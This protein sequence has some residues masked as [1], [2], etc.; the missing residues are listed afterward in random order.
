MG[1]GMGMGMNIMNM[2]FVGMDM[3]QFDFN[4]M[5]MY[6]G[7]RMSVLFFFVYFIKVEYVLGSFQWGVMDG[8]FV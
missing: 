6:Q 4:N 5:V 2:N 3:G 8:G 1:M 7:L